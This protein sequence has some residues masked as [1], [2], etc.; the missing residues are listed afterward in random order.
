S[1]HPKVIECLLAGGQTLALQLLQKKEAWRVSNV[2]RPGL[3][4]CQDTGEFDNG[5]ATARPPDQ[6][7]SGQKQS[8]HKHPA[9][10]FRSGFQAA[11]PELSLALSGPE[12]R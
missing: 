3:F 12:Q 9:H 8:V 4:A 10:V 1:C 5:L 2:R 11:L 6:R 7:R